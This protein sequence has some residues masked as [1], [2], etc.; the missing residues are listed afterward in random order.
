M[1]SDPFININLLEEG[2]WAIKSRLTKSAIARK[3]KDFLIE[4]IKQAQSEGLI[5]NDA[6]A[7]QISDILQSVII[8]FVFSWWQEG[9]QQEKDLKGVTV[10]VM[11]LFLNGAKK[12]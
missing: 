9:V 11:D 7:A 8:S 4:L 6:E 2:R 1:R 3:R 10:I 5:R 12:R